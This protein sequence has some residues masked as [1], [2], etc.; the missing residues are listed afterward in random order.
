[1]KK[2]LATALAMMVS[3]AG[4]AQVLLWDSEAP[5]KRVTLGLRGGLNVSNIHLSVDNVGADLD[6]KIG[7]RFGVS[8]DFGIV[9]SFYINTGLYYS[10]KGAKA[11]GYDEDFGG[12]EMKMSPAYLEIPVYA[13]YRINFAENSQLQINF[14]PYMAF[15]VNGKVKVGSEEVDFF[16]DDN[17]GGRR[18][19]AGLGVGAGYTFSHFYVGLDY[20]FG[21]T[22]MADTDGMGKITNKNLNISVG[23][24]F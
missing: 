19:D 17:A 21:L 2:I 1:M 8:A 3:F 16:G 18:F 5:E 6:S 10:A 11:D 24:N 13:S 7:Y 14:G 23:Y 4:F 15:G 22:N 12:M 9:K 20:Q